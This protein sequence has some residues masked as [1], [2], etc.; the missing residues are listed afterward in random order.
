MIEY[1]KKREYEHQQ[2]QKCLLKL[3]VIHTVIHTPHMQ[4]EFRVK[5]HMFSEHNISFAMSIAKLSNK[6]VCDM[7]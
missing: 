6:H 2:Q 3:F 7:L 5:Y 1:Q 4:V